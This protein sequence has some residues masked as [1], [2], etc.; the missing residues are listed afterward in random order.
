LLG[1]YDVD[2]DGSSNKAFIFSMGHFTRIDSM[3]TARQY[4]GLA[5]DE[6]YVY[7]VGGY[8]SS[9]GVLSKCERM[10][11]QTRRWEEIVPLNNPRMNTGTIK[12]GEK[13]LYAFGGQQN[14]AVFLDTVERYNLDLNIWTVLEILLPEKLS[15]LTCLQAANNTLMLFGGLK[16]TKKSSNEKD[17]I[18]I[19]EI[20]KNAYFYNTVR[21]DIVSRQFC[22][23]KKKLQSAQINGKG[24]IYCLYM[25]NNRE[26]PRLFIADLNEVYE[27]YS[28]YS[29][30][31]KL[32]YRE[33]KLEKLEISQNYD[34]A[35]DKK[36]SSGVE[37][38]EIGPKQ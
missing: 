23:F 36:E 4:F 35:N 16:F 33:K 3:L 29:W 8:N 34:F 9:E 6:S 13:Y 11:I 30:M 15:N 31:L 5:L 19:P 10:H 24:H 14:S 32:G 26:L 20:D 21:Q 27:E 18:L 28:P 22:S 37:M 2:L 7:V 12:V 25:N 38:I 17:E 1:G